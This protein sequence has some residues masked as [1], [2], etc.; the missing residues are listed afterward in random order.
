MHV[1][2]RPGPASGWDPLTMPTVEEA[3]EE[4]MQQLRAVLSH[5]CFACNGTRVVSDYEAKHR[6]IEAG[7]LDT[8]LLSTPC[9][10]CGPTGISEPSALELA[11]AVQSAVIAY[12]YRSLAAN[13]FDRCHRAIEWGHRL[14]MSALGTMSPEDIQAGVAALSRASDD[15]PIEPGAPLGGALTAEEI[16][17]LTDEPPKSEAT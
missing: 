16:A 9:D 7:D 13:D 11:Q 15:P 2:G 3:L 10:S 6:A 5:P 12:A 1:H 17:G 8:E 4:T 14:N